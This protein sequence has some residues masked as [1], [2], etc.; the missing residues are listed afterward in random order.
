[1]QRIGQLGL[2]ILV[3]DGQR[4]RVLVGIQQRLGQV[5]LFR[6][7]A[8]QH[9][10]RGA[11]GVLKLDLLGQGGKEA[12]LHPLVLQ[13][14]KASLG[15]GELLVPVQLPGHVLDIPLAAALLSAGRQLL[16]DLIGALLQALQH[17][18]VELS[19]LPAHNHVHRLLMA[20]GRLVYPLGGERVIYIGHGHNLGRN[21]YLIPRQPVRVAPPVPALVVPAANLI[22]KA[23]QRL[24]LIGGQVFQHLRAHH[25][26]GF[27]NGKLLGGEFARLIQ[28][29][30]RDGDLADIVEGG[31][32]ADDG[33]V[34]LADVVA[35]GLAQQGVEQGLGQD[36][37]VA[38]MHTALAVAELHAVAEYVDHQAAALLLFV[39]LLGHHGGQP[40]LLGVEQNG[41]HHPAVDNERVKGT[42][43]EV[44]DAQLKGPFNV[45][46]PPLRRDH[47]NRDV[48]NPAVFVHLREHAEAV[49]HRHYDVQQHQGNFGA[50]LL[51]HG[52]ALFAVFRLN[53]IKFA[54]QHIRQNCPVHLRVVH[55]QYFLPVRDLLQGMRP[56]FALHVHPRPL[57]R[58]WRRSPAGAVAV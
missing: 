42:A 9:Q 52:H 14:L 49:H 11:D 46:G 31:G 17:Q 28:N 56:P 16:A 21:G 4:L 54:V 53:D 37:Y 7:P 57:S 1:M 26:M 13:Q 44:G 29:F 51:Q 5:Q 35:V 3:D 24:I 10:G 2:H 34:R 33:D 36:M 15:R 58:R 47:N 25:G 6:A 20:E 43:D 12:V 30:L 39:D 27:H 23:Y 40:L 45:A 48:L 50:V 19:A 32:G 8:V 18:G 22:G 38:H 55:N 41:V